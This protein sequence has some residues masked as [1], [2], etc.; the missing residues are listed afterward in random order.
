MKDNALI[1]TTKEGIQTNFTF[2]NED[3]NKFS[4]QIAKIAIDSVSRNVQLAKIFGRVL[5]TQCYK[6]DG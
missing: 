4:A 6:E 5:D 2:K 1:A 3:L